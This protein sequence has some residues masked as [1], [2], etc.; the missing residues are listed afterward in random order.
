MSSN[1]LPIVGE[2][3]YRGKFYYICDSQGNIEVYRATNIK[4]LISYKKQ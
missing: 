1:K 3:E 2:I 4:P